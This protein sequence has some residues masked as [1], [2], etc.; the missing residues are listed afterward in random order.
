[1]SM[2]AAERVALLVSVAIIAGFGVA[3][4]FFPR[5]D[6]ALRSFFSEYLRG[7]VAVLV[8]LV[9]LWVALASVNLVVERPARALQVTV[10]ALWGIVLV[11]AIALVGTQARRRRLF[12]R[13]RRLGRLTPWL[14][15]VDVLALAV[16]FFATLSYLLWQPGYLALQ[17]AVGGTVTTDLLAAFYLWHF[18]DAVPLLDVNGTLQWPV[19]ATYADAAS[20]WLLLAFKIVVI[21]PVIAAFRGAWE[22]GR[23]T[24]PEPV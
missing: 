14:Y 22:R 3:S 10:L 13:L 1:V 5:V 20:G 24:D 12:S 8:A 16:M 7:S 21:L 9:P 23:A 17:P 6:A 2:S 15:S 18:L 11:T 4:A 19:P